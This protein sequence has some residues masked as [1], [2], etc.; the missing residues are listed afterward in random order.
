MPNIKIT[1]FVDNTAAVTRAM[2][3]QLAAAAEDIKDKALDSVLWMMLYGYNEPHGEDGH[4]EIYDTGALYRSIEAKVDTKKVVGLGVQDRFDVIVSANTEYASY[5][6]QGTYKLHGRPFITD[7]I[8][9]ITHDIETT[10]KKHLK[11]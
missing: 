1:K 8:N 10:I 2:S 4:T 6:H 3:T 5:V 11:D 7:G 9:R